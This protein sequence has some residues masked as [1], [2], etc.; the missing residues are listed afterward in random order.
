MCSF[1]FFF[2]A[3]LIPLMN[4]VSTWPGLPGGMLLQLL[5][6][7]CPAQKDSTVG[8]GKDFLGN[9]VECGH[10][11]SVAVGT[12]LLSGWQA[13]DRWCCCPQEPSCSSVGELV[14]GQ[15][16]KGRQLLCGLL[17]WSWAGRARSRAAQILHAQ[18]WGP[19]PAEGR[20]RAVFPRFLPIPSSLP[21]ATYLP[22]IPF[23]KWW[24]L[25]VRKCG[26]YYLRI[27]STIKGQL[28]RAQLDV[29]ISLFLSP[30]IGHTTSKTEDFTTYKD[31]SDCASWHRAQ[32]CLL[33][34][35]LHKLQ[36]SSLGIS[37]NKY[38]ACALAIAL[39]D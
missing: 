5:L 20:M 17:S 21:K 14:T 19:Q 32:T 30:P 3:V 34:S 18:G 7:V 37:G 24:H 8:Q 16:L 23:Y 12:S 38:N 6:K 4:W 27:E 10:V 9:V 35:S 15:V 11:P 2:L 22:M 33:L 25:R 1:T 31:R 39:P 28:V 29:W 26:I 13:G 36:L